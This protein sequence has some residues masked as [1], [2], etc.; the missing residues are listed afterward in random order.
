[1]PAAREWGRATALDRRAGAGGRRTGRAAVR[2]DPAFREAGAR[3]TVRRDPALR[4]KTV[5]WSAGVAGRPAARRRRL[6]RTAD[7]AQPMFRRRESD[8]S[9]AEPER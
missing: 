3:P 8:D 6:T 2:R 7:A 5:A 1:M 4:P 9:D